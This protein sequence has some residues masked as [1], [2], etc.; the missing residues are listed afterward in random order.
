[1]RLPGNVDIE[2]EIRQLHIFPKEPEWYMWATFRGHLTSAMDKKIMGVAHL[3]FHV[4]R[5]LMAHKE[6]TK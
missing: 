1:M 2:R 5:N 3:I 4:L 6:A